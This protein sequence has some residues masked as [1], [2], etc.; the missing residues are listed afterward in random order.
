MHLFLKS[1]FCIKPQLNLHIQWIQIYWQDLCKL[2][3]LVEKKNS[4][5]MELLQILICC[6]FGIPHGI[7]G[8]RI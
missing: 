3:L 7:K 2:V 8:T 6:I 5:I 1:N 4:T